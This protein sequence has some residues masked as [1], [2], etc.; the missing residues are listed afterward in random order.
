MSTAIV[1][2]AVPLLELSKFV[3]DN[4]SVA[5]YPEPTADI[6]HEVIALLAFTIISTVQPV[7]VPPVVAIPV[8]VPCTGVPLTEGVPIVNTEPSVSPATFEIITFEPV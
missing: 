8:Y 6:V 2:S 7:P 4:V 5:R 1:A 3:I